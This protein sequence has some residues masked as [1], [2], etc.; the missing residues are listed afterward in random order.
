MNKDELINEFIKDLK[1]N[2][3][4]LRK[5]QLLQS[6]AR[7]A[8]ENSEREIDKM[9]ETANL[10]FKNRLF[11]LQELKGS[12]GESDKFFNNERLQ[13]AAK[14]CAELFSSVTKETKSTLEPKMRSAA[15]KVNDALGGVDLEGLSRKARENAAP[16]FSFVVEA[17]KKNAKKI[18]E[19]VVDITLKR[20]VN[21]SLED[22]EQG[23]RSLKNMLNSFLD[24]RKN[25]SERAPY[26]AASSQEEAV[27]QALERAAS[28]TNKHERY[29]NSVYNLSVFSWLKAYRPDDLAKIPVTQAHIEYAKFCETHAFLALTKFDFLKAL[30]EM[31]ILIRTIETPEGEEVQILGLRAKSF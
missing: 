1:A 8:M 13:E 21:R 2:V 24:E 4:Q 18:S 17:A 20:A 3:I 31:N 14:M 7:S 6:S 27:E 29:W 22:A 12:D 16:L 5:L 25:T 30:S 23:V 9:I 10:I 15:E 19:E 11:F 28:D 26:R